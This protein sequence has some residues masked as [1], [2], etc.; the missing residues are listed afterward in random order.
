ML[1]AFS[2]RHGAQI[3]VATVDPQTRP[4]QIHRWY[5]IP[6]AGIGGILCTPAIGMN[7]AEAEAIAFARHLQNKLGVGSVDVAYIPLSQSQGHDRHLEF[8]I[9][10]GGAGGPRQTGRI[11]IGKGF[12]FVDYPLGPTIKLFTPGAMNG[13]TYNDATII[14]RT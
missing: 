11:W 5:Q 14:S 10:T 2:D 12:D 7:L 3:R 1:G 9:E 8:V 4:G 6:K 13:A